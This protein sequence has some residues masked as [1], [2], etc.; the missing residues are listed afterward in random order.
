MNN[1]NIV[2]GINGK[3]VGSDGNVAI[4]A[5]NILYDFLIFYLKFEIYCYISMIIYI[6]AI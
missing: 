5:L 4:V 2:P 3:S 6:S 1:S